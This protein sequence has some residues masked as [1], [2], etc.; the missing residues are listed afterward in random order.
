MG[1]SF[2]FRLF[3]FFS[4][5]NKVIL[6]LLISSLF[7]FVFSFF[8]IEVFQEGLWKDTSFEDPDLQ[9]LSSKL[10]ATV[11]LTRAPGTVNMYDRAFRKW[12]EFALRKKELSYFPA[13][14]M[15]VPVYLQYVLESTR[16]SA[17]V[18]TAFYSFK[19]AHESAGLVSPTDNPLVNRVW[20]AAKR[21][22]GTKRD[23]RKEPLSVEISRI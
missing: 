2:I 6:L 13:N 9:S 11:L 4:C 22:L 21:I 15:H 17:S 16:S 19:R 7:C 14:P 8:R 12:R 1:G 23:N 20:D 18:D 10:Q 5:H 3:G